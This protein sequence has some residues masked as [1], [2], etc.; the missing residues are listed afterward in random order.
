M[1]GN[2]VTKKIKINPKN[3]INKTNCLKDLMDLPKYKYSQ[4]NNKLIEI[5]H[6]TE[7]D[8]IYIT[9]FNIYIPCAKNLYHCKRSGYTGPTVDPS[10]KGKSDLFSSLANS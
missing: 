9:P 6:E 8:S 2:Q 1:I 10:F 4:E 5:E 7:K 3:I